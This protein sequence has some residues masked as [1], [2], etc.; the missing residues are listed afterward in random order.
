MLDREY[1][2][3]A[4]GVPGEIYI[5]GV[6]LARGYLNRA[7]LTAESFIPNPF[8][9]E[10]GERL[11]RTGDVGRYLADGQIDFL[12]R[13]DHQVKIRGYRIELGEIESILSEH[14]AVREAVVVVK[15][16]RAN[17]KR[18]VVYLVSGEVE[19]PADIAVREYLRQRLPEHM[20]PGVFVWL[21]RLPLTPNGKVDRRALSAQDIVQPKTEQNYLA[22]R[23]P[24]EEKL[25]E[26]WQEVLGSERV[27]VNDNFFELG[28]HSLLATQV[29]S[30]VRDAFQTELPLRE[31]FES[32]TIAGLARAIGSSEEEPMSGHF[33]PILPAERNG[34][35]PLSF[36][37]QRLWFLDQLTPGNP[38]YNMSG[39]F[40][41]LMPLH[42]SALEKSFGEIIRRHEV[43]RTTFSMHDDK[44]IQVVKPEFKFSLPIIDLSKLPENVRQ[45]EAQRVTAQETQYTF[46]LSAG[47]LFRATLLRFG[48]MDNVLLLS[49]HHIVSD[50]WSMGVFLDELTTLYEAYLRGLESPLTELP[51]QYADF[52]LWQQ[53]Y[54]TGEVL[55][56]ELT[57]WR[58][59]LTGVPPVLELPTDRP[60]PAVQRFRGAT[61][62]FRLSSSSFDSIKILCQRENVTLFIT[63]LTALKVL[64]HYYTGVFDLV[65]GTFD[66]KSQPG[67]I[68]EINRIFC[69]YSCFADGYERRS[70]LR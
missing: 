14:P 53:K 31:L 61:Q 26:I 25:V 37:Q 32:P 17:D 38:I 30:R 60:R 45:L 58:R 56:R 52:V 36:S 12:G 57:Y 1:Q 35:I 21:E 46:D 62:T 49:M 15:E 65:V 28:G 3:V 19:R 13:A 55:E 64:L 10:G 2:P 27:G 44:P 69:Q 7:E 67:G 54:L 16:E 24:V 18:L 22:A 5:G 6:G 20:V 47:P 43:L 41:I 9:R 68:R 39:A 11:Y 70:D 29:I 63:L 48:D 50:G 23:T 40:H 42:T 66:R 51:I 4:V 59:Q 8:G 33:S 34:N